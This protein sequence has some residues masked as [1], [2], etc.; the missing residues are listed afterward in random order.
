M[1]QSGAYQLNF[2]CIFPF[3][4]RDI[5][6]TWHYK[7]LASAALVSAILIGMSGFRLPFNYDVNEISRSGLIINPLLR[8]WPLA[9]CGVGTFSRSKNRQRGGTKLEL[10]VLTF[11][12]LRWH[13][14][15]FRNNAR[16]VVNN[17][18][19]DWVHKV[20]APTGSFASILSVE[21][22]CRNN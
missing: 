9:S 3:L 7:L 6:K 1:T 2:Y 10:S 11:A 22:E 15:H 8:S 21:K 13:P 14:Y 19:S 18:P 17:A 20:V 5:E 16:A 12:F 4:L